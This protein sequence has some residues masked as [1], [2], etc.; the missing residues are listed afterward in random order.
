ML[1]CSVP[2]VT[3]AARSC[4]LGLAEAAWCSRQIYVANGGDLE[5]QL[6]TFI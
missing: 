6:Y 1:I 5:G 2:V 3:N 4:H